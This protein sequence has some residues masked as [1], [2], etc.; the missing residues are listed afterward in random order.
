MKSD[1]E[2]V[3][4][5]IRYLEIH[6]MNNHHDKDMNYVR[7]YLNALN[8]LDLKIKVLKEKKQQIIQYELPQL[9]GNF[10]LG[11]MIGIIIGI[12]LY[13]IFEYFI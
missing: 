7:G 6:M 10:I 12:I 13:P 4:K 8:N 5:E 11:F 3:E 2:N 9:I 1:L